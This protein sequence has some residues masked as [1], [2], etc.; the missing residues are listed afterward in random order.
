LLHGIGSNSY[1]W[2]EVM[3]LFSEAGH[4]VYAPDWLGH[5]SSDKVRS[6]GARAG[7]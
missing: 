2:R 1:G 3:A 4:T 6:A 5:G 7:L